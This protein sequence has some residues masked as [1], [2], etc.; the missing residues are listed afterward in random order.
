MRVSWS[1]ASSTISGLLK[2][3]RLCETVELNGVWF[4]DYQAPFAEWP[5]LYVVLTL[6]GSNTNKL[7]IG[8]LVT[9]VLRRHPMVTAH[10][11][12]SLSHIAPNRLIL[13]LGAGAGSSHF[14]YGI[15]LDHLAT[16][17]K[18]GIK[19]IKALWTSTSEKPAHF[20][21]KYFRLEKAGSPLKPASNIPIYV[22]SYGPK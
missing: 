8:S 20:K 13:G 2:E 14:Y 1:L 5:E 22:A 12:A 4:P 6:L 7:L 10:A 16:R 9:D 11:F 17:L 18:E 21:G 3:A 19:V 15:K